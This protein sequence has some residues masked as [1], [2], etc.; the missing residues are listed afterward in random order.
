MIYPSLSI[1]TNSHAV[2]I[3]VMYERELELNYIGDS[4]TFEYSVIPQ[5]IDFIN[6]DETET[7]I[8][9]KIDD[10]LRLVR[11]EYYVK[12]M[13][14]NSDGFSV[15]V[16]T[17]HLL[18]FVTVLDQCL[19]IS[20]RGVLPLDIAALLDQLYNKLIMNG[21]GIDYAWNL[22]DLIEHHVPIKVRNYILKE[23][24]TNRDYWTYTE[25]RLNTWVSDLCYI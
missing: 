9:C 16:P 3:C 5:V 24:L 23:Y 22:M 8:R 19:D 13:I 4:I 17:E 15:N 7:Y 20:K 11:H 14:A 6:S 1:G 2:I 25:S 10:N 18:E 12:F 21:H